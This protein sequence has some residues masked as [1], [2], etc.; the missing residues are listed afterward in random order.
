MNL[1]AGLNGAAVAVDAR[2]ARRPGMGIHLYLRQVVRLLVEAGAAVT[3]ITNFDTT[4]YREDFPGVEWIAEEC[5]YNIVWEQVNLPRLLRHHEFDV[6]WAP[7]NTG[8]PFPS[9]GHTLCVWTL[10]DLVALRLPG[11]YLLRRPFYAAPYLVW[12][13]A[14]AVRSDLI[15]TDSSASA[16]DIRSLCRR[17]A[18]VAPPVWYKDVVLSEAGCGNAPEELATDLPDGSRYL[19][20]NGGLDPRKNV[21]TLLEAFSLAVRSDPELLLVLMG[22]G[23]ETLGPLYAELDIADNVVLTGYVSET[24]KARILR[25]AVALV[26]LSLYEGYGLPILE[27]LAHGTPVVT[28][29]NSSLPEVA[30]DAALYVDTTDLEAIAGAMQRVQDDEVRAR[31]RA[32]GGARWSAYDAEAIRASVTQH[33]AEALQRKR[34]GVTRRRSSGGTRPS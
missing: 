13:A 30:G 32:A 17:T 28:A 9:V 18:V 6:Y 29:T 34:D 14:G 16:R 26:Y 4:E 19:L 7:A 23:Y 3:L 5:R 31:L 15:F 1:A 21:R 2:Y 11:M 33:V 24:V 8:I 27:A 22:R 25:G 20:Y 10:H 12:T